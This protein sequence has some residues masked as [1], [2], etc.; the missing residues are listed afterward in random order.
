MQIRL[1]VRDADGFN[2]DVAV[3]APA[4]TSLREFTGGIAA[5][6]PRAEG[7]DP[8]LWSGSRPLPATAMLGGPG[9]RTGDI[10]DVD[11]L[12]TGISRQ[13]RSCGSISSAGQTLDWSP[14]YLVA[15]S[16]SAAR[17]VAM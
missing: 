16:R 6:L 5:A 11:H 4:G 10:I 12:A 3:S 17:R 7:A 13:A 1:S 14:R 15:S 2:R 8:A 9:L